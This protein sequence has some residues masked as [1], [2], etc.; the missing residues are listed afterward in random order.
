[1]MK[2]PIYQTQRFDRYAEVIQQLIDAG[3]AYR[4]YCSKQRLETL[5]TQQ[6]AN[7]EKP[8]YDEKCRDLDAASKQAI[9]GDYVIRFRNPKEG[10]VE[11]DD[12][13]R[14]TIRIANRELDDLIIARSDGTPTYNLT[15]VVDDL[16][17][18]ISHVIRG[19]DHINNTPRQIN[20]MHAL[21]AT[22]P[23]YAHVPMILGADGKRLSKRHGAVG[24]MQ[25]R[26]EGYLP[27]ALLNYLV[28]LGWS[29][30]DQEVFSREEM[31]DLFSLKGVNKSPSTFNPEKLLWLNQ[32]YLKNLDIDEIATQLTW[33]LKQQQLD[34][35]HG[36]AINDVI[37]AAT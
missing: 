20:I 3:K 2:P 7:K 37:A 13:V 30:G 11:I 16:D 34:I 36:P 23:Q 21:G 14:G 24:V 1:M 26:D 28:R 18:G 9:A 33:H 15:V 12:L 31:I 22:P 17:M 4:C 10:V 8:R 25:Y 27:Q 19:D 35:S 6:M 29:H 32:Y 5:R